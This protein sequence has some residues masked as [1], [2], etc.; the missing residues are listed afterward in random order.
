MVDPWL[1]K[2]A[3]KCKRVVAKR[4]AKT[5]LPFGFTMRHVD[6]LRRKI[7][8][9]NSPPYSDPVKSL[10]ISHPGFR[11]GNFRGKLDKTR[12]NGGVYS[13]C[14]GL[15]RLRRSTLNRVAGQS[16][17]TIAYEERMLA[18]HSIKQTD[19]LTKRNTAIT[20]IFITFL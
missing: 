12:E 20:I 15:N 7:P 14:Y 6:T 1:H 4:H 16:S 8:A 17:I 11:R 19:G 18:K 5:R 10:R 2:I 13:V 3:M 9:L